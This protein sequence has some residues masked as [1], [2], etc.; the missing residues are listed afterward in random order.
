MQ[1]TCDVCWSSPQ[2]AGES[3][4]MRSF[5][6]CTL[7]Q[8]LLTYKIKENETSVVNSV[9]RRT[10]K[11]IRNFSRKAEGKRLLGRIGCK[12]VDWIHLAQDRDQ[13]W[14]VVNTVMNIR[15]L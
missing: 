3:C 7:R 4:I 15:V 5:I 6:I 1:H 14:A 2:E 12:D 11:F 8:I 9:I 10:E 13:W